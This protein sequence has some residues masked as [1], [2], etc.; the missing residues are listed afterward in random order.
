M[1]RLGDTPSRMI[2]SKTNETYKQ[3][4]AKG[5]QTPKRRGKWQH[6]ETGGEARFGPAKNSDGE[7]VRVSG[8]QKK[9]CKAEIGRCTSSLL[10]STPHERP[11]SLP[12]YDRP[13]DL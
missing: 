11:V 5:R 1:T 13:A 10:V 4:L 3:E 2:R 6:G 9:F 8:R 12:L 7:Q